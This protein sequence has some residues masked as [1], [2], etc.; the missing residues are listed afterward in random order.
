MATTL[1]TIQKI[2]EQIFRSDAA[3]CR[4]IETLDALGRGAVSQD[5]LSNLRTFVEHIMLK[6]YAHANDTTYD[7][8]HIEKA[9]RFVKTKGQLKF[10]WRFHAYLQIVVSHY[11]LDPEDSERVML[12]Y[13]EFMLKIK[14]YLKTQHGLDVLANLDQFPLNTDRNLQEY[15]EK[16]AEK[17]AS[18]NY[19]TDIAS[20]ENARYYIH[21]IKPFFVHQRIY[22]EVTFIPA[23]GRASKFD[24]IIAFTTLDISKYYA[25]KLWTVE[26]SITILGKT[27]PIFIIANWE[28]AIRPIEIEKLSNIF[29][30]ELQSYA[31]S[32]EGRGLMQFLT[33]TGFNLV[34]LLCFEDA[35]YQQIRSQVLAAFNAKVSHL[36]DLFDRCR[37]I[38][39]SNR[40]GSNVLRYLLYHLNNRV[41]SDQI[42]DEN[43]RLSGLYLA[44][45]CIPFDKMPFNTSL[46]HHNPRLSDLFDCLDATNRMHEVLARYVHVNTEKQG[47]LYTSSA[48]LERFGDID[49]LVN[50]FNMRLYHNERHQARRI[51]TRNG[52]YYIRGYENDTVEIIRKLIDLS[53]DGVQN[54]TS[55]V[56]GWLASAVHPVDCEEK[57]AALRQMF[58]QSSVALIYGSA[59][60]GKSTLINHISNLFK[61]QSKLY[62]A[63]TNPAV[64]NMKRRVTVQTDDIDFMTIAKFLPSQSIRVKYD[65]VVID[66]CSTV[67]NRD[68]KAI[69]DKAEFNLLVLVGDIYQ[70]EAIEFGNWFSA[71]RGFLPTTS[72]Y[73]LTKPY[74]SHNP[75]LQTLWDRVRSMDD[76]IVETIARNQYSVSLDASIFVPAE[77]DEVILCLNYDGLYGIN[78]INRFL[79]EANPNPAVTWGLQL[80]KVGDPILFNESD[81]FKPVIYNNIKGWIAGIKLVGDQI[82]FDIE[83][84]RPINGL[85]ARSCDFELLENSAAGRSVIR[86]TVDDHRKADE[87]QEVPITAVVP[88]QVA[89]AVSIHKAQGLEFNS[90]KIVITDEI[91]DHITH[92]IFYTAITRAR[93]KL[94]IYWTP[95]VGQKILSTIK[96]KDFNRDIAFLRVALNERTST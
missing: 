31:G 93:E 79:Q 17:L 40:S 95:E 72:V 65:I 4:H 23:T 39:G 45:G 56:D 7:Y 52:H 87:N 47:Q 44:Y 69:L 46:L 90:V 86:F 55:Y 84:D 6:I 66:E 57:K 30:E 71:A 50:T 83:V 96:P 19:S 94:K 58:A 3:I 67:N 9:I 70:I 5:I 38:I 32:A 49:T 62:L 34:E 22:Y 37:E 78:N 21:K 82:Q 59:G 54:Y 41:I 63:N 27:M 75:E 48:E 61:N 36:F 89:Y 73:E 76:R 85:E 68:M 33:R 11:T 92:S 35:H 81:R 26:D 29:G 88:F 15:Y 20:S 64:D 10:L 24:R 42:G 16:I 74:R 12:K 53:A 13:Y 8:Q 18:R 14:D 80:Y 91:E 77:P 28:V 60:T 43:S 51:E 1:E 2:D 25:V